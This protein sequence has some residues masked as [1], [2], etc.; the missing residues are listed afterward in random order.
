MAAAVAALSCEEPVRIDGWGAVA[1]SYPG[2]LTDL[3]KLRGA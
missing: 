3:A 2:F 1:T